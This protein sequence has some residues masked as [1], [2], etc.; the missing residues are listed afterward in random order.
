MDC[1]KKSR[2]KSKFS[3]QPYFLSLQFLGYNNLNFCGYSVFSDNVFCL[4]ISYS[5]VLIKIYTYK[6]DFF[7]PR[8][9]KYT[10]CTSFKLFAY[11]KQSTQFINFEKNLYFLNFYTS[12]KKPS[13][14]MICI[15]KLCTNDEHITANKSNSKRKYKNENITKVILDSRYLFW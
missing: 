3:L 4:Y 9:K 5:I 15:K 12:S 7:S 11:T 14:K 13:A 1:G 6:H 2:K 10:L 8:V